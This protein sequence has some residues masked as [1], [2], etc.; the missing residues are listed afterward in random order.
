M[1]IGFARGQKGQ[2]MSPEDKIKLGRA[3]RGL[4][5]LHE[6]TQA[7]VAQAIGLTQGP[8]SSLEKGYGT[9]ANFRL[10]CETFGH[11]PESLLAWLDAALSPEDQDPAQESGGER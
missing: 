11:T 4:R 7:D 6:K 9:E 10:A 1:K 2:K 3:L 8:Y 5:G